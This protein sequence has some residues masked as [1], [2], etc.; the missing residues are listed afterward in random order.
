MKQLV[1][2]VNQPIKKHFLL[3][4]VVLLQI[5][6]LT[7]LFSGRTMRIADCFFGM[8]NLILFV[9]APILKFMTILETLTKGQLEKLYD[10]PKSQDPD[11]Y[12]KLCTQIKA[13]CA[14]ED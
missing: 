9:E 13:M 1:S 3:T 4:K 12:T 2:L 14:K 11:C 5:L 10:I 8:L 7:C 6:I